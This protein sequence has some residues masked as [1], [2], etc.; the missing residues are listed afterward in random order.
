MRL[1]GFKPITFF[2]IFH[3][4]PSTLLPMIFMPAV[5]ISYHMFNIISLCLSFEVTRHPTG[6][7]CRVLQL[8]DM[9]SNILSTCIGPIILCLPILPMKYASKQYCQP[10]VLSLLHVSRLLGVQSYLPAWWRAQACPVGY[11]SFCFFSLGLRH[12][13]GV[14]EQSPTMSSVTI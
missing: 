5:Q 1:C 14:A 9:L 10:C 2:A 8:S 12:I 11:F 6:Q 4:F 7:E 3:T 13:L